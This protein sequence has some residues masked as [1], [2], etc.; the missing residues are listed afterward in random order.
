MDGNKDRRG[1]MQIL[2]VED[3][4]GDIRLTLE[5]FRDANPN[6]QL[7]TASDG[8]E[9][10]AFLRRNG[11]HADAPR[12]ELILLDLNMPKKD[13]RQVLAERRNRQFL[14]LRIKSARGCILA[15][16]VHQ[17]TEIV[18]QRSGDERFVA[19]CA[20]HKPCRL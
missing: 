13:G 10:M 6:L 16:G 15:L 20:L 19:A 3:S 1:P 18:Q 9:A 5:A 4:P 17:V 12:P 11:A 8:V 2:L 14:V 7:H